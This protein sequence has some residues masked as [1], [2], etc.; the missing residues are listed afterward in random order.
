VKED[1]ARVRRIWPGFAARPRRR[2][3]SPLL[4][5]ALMAKVRQFADNRLADDVCIVA[6]RV[7]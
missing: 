4:G 5:A 3:R 1:P 6:A 2:T 7:A